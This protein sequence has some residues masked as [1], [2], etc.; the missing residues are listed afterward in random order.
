MNV[1]F[2]TG[3][4]DKARYLAQWLGHD[5]PHQ[6]IDLPEIQSLE[7]AEVVAHKA[8]EAYKQLGSPVLVEDVSLSFAA[9]DD[10]LPGTFVKWFLET[11]GN[12]GM[13]KML[14]GFDDRRAT[15]RIMYALYDGH[16]LHTF[17][18]EMP[19][20]IAA[21]IATSKDSGWKSSKSWNAIFIP[22]G[23]TKTYAEMTDEELQPFSH[24]AQA[25]EKLRIFLDQA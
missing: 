22:E 15:A 7:L 4:Q 16:T 3:N 13:L 8:H 5:V 20:S 12:E 10:R 23:S 14:A 18:G 9:L 1:T 25:I 11:V 19:G 21:A 24:R 17:G 2:I 6:K